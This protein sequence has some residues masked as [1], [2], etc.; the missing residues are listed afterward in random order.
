MNYNKQIILDVNATGSES[1]V[2]VK[3]GDAYSRFINIQLLADGKEYVPDEGATFLLRCQK[4]DGKA[5]VLDSQFID[6]ELERYLIIKNEDN[7][8]T[9]ELVP[10]ITAVVG[11]CKCDL[12]MILNESVLSTMTFIINV[13]RSPDIAHQIVSSDDFRTL[14]NA[15]AAAGEIHDG[16]SPTVTVTTI[17]GGHR[18]SITD[19]NGTTS[20]DVMDGSGGGGEVGKEVIAATYDSTATYAVGDYCWYD[21]GFYQCTTAITTAEAWNSTHWTAVSVGSELSGLTRQLSDK[22]DKTNYVTL[23]G[24]IIT[25]TAVDNTMYLCGEL[26]E[27]TF[28]APASGQTAIRFSTGTTATVASFPGVTWLNGFNPS[29]LETERMYEINILNLVGVASWT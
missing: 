14:N 5:V 15:I 28:T 27:L 19:V 29:S 26:A 10:Q 20:F 6:E 18:V 22:Q 12:T 16:Y 2:N 3:Q 23:T 4:P 25:Q 1:V 17:T 24:T 7:T 21:G 9:V 13:L 11:R 8:V